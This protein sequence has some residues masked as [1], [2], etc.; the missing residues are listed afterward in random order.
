MAKVMSP[1]VFLPFELELIDAEPHILSARLPRQHFHDPFLIDALT[2]RLGVAKYD[3]DPVDGRRFVRRLIPSD[4][5][6]I[7]K[8]PLSDFIPGKASTPAELIFLFHMGR[9][10]STLLA[11]M[12]AT[13]PATF[14]LSEPT[15]INRLLD[16]TMT[17]LTEESR[18]EAVLAAINAYAACR[19]PQAKRVVIKFRSWNIL[20]AEGLLGAF[21]AARL[22][23]VHRNSVEVW[24]SLK[25]SPPGWLRSTHRLFESGSDGVTD[26]AECEYAAAVLGRLCVS[27]KG[28][29][30][31]G[32]HFVD[33]VDLVSSFLILARKLK[34]SLSKPEEQAAIAR[35]RTYSK[36]LAAHPFRSDSQS[37]QASVSAEESVIMKTR[38][39]PKRAELVGGHSCE[40]SYSL[41][42]KDS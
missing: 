19:P 41:A 29:R 5:A 24:A 11:Q 8:T 18:R 40:P 36:S 34:I 33:Y 32:C 20:F 25:R 42:G 28:L 22:C 13:S 21:P 12:L 1:D 37:K 7:H 10:G 26:I 16:P 9:A 3:S 15:L 30:R 4:T 14:V 17:I 23:F 31:F 38:V 35:S 27:A 2:G 6:R 39:E